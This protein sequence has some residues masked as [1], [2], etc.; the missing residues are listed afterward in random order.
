[1]STNRK[2]ADEFARMADVLELLGENRFRVAAYQ[3]AARVLGELAENVEDLAGD[4]NDL[5]AIEGIG[6]G[7]AEKIIEFVETGRI[8]EHAQTI[9]KVPKGVLELM[10]IPGLGPKTLATFWKQ[11]DI[12]SLK[13]LKAAIK[14]GELETLPR[15][16]KKSVEKLAKSIAFAES[17]GDRVRLGE[18]LPV[19]LEILEKMR[20][21]KAVVKA[22]YAG[23]LR[24]GKETIGDV[25]ILVGVADPEK[26]A[27]AVSKAFASM[28][29]V[30]DVIA[31]GATKTSVRT[32][33][34]LQ[35]D[36]RVVSADQYGAALLYFTGSKE[37]NVAMRERA[38][39]RDL[40]L[41]EYGLWKADA[42]MK[43]P[44]THPVAA[45]T[46]ADIFK[47]LDL[48]YIEPEMREDRGELSA[49]EDGTLP[50]LIKLSDIKAELHAH[51]V[52]SDGLWSIEELANAAKA[53]G[54]HTVAVT[55]HSRAQAVAN[56]LD[57]KRLIRHI[58]DVRAADKKISGIRILAGSEVDILS[59]GKMDYSDKILSQLDLVVAS[60]H[61]ALSQDDAKATKRLLR[62]IENPY[63]HIIGHPTGR[64][65]NRR[66][67]LQPDMAKLIQ[68]A[69]ETGT[70]LEINAH[71][72]RLDLRDTHA[73]AAIE[74]GA[75]LAINTDAHGPGDLDH[76]GFGILTAR[77][78]WAEAKHV[79]NCFT[80]AK[81]KKWL[82]A[83]RQKMVG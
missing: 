21:L 50:D 5:V 29:C 38:I 30:Q 82:T 15:M 10:A 22:D 42:D 26:S 12:T 53:R 59:D 80:A 55:D 72:W 79:V 28:D 44:R 63:V 49:A 17:A 52:A 31:A 45:R 32:D 73:R 25:D 33:K 60:P 68:A 13:K 1:M 11:A 3:R 56:G 66:A 47:K 43:N 51:T 76:L 54:F 61:M 39:R 48:A 83:K 14:T 58:E 19:A 23:S 70:A 41:N 6:K 74:A 77:R 9:K 40:R 75:L 7:L 64:L 18:A 71:H 65:I 78:A 24:R 81:L 62:A 2:L 20:S 46:E 36:L 34:N 27:A 37:N 16:G 69:A 8:A 57:E 35:A 67:G 4:T